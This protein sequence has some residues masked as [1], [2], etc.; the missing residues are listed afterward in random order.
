MSTSTQLSGLISGFD[1]KSFIDSTISYESVPINRMQREQTTNSA[2]YDA[3]GSLDGLL[4]SLRTSAQALGSSSSFYARTTSLAASTAS[5]SASADTGAALGAYKVS[6]TQ[7]ATAARLNGAGDIT[8]GLAATADVSGLTLS[9][10][11]LANTLTAGTF[12]VNGQQVTVDLADS[13]QDVFDAIATATSGAVTASYDPVTDTVALA[14]SGEIVLGAANDTSNFLS[15]FRLHNNGTASVASSTAL[16]ALA[17]SAPIASAGLRSAVTA[18]DGAG[19][20]SFSINGVSLDYNVNT[21]TVAS[22]IARINAS[23]AGV[24]ASYD[25]VNDRVVL[26]N[27]V[28]GD[29]GVTVT[30]AAGGL[31][32]ALG[33]T[34]GALTRGKNALY[35]IDDGP[36][37]VSA[38][39]TLAADSHGVTGLRLT[40]GATGTDTINVGAD[41]SAMKTKIQAFVT[42]YNNVQAYIDQQTK[43]TKTENVVSSATLTN[44]REVQAWSS[45]LRSKVFAAVGGLSGTVSRLESLGIDFSSSDST[46][47]VKSTT[48]LDAALAQ[49]PDDVAAFFATA[50]TG[51]AARLV[52]SINLI[53][54]D[55]YG[56]KGYIDNRQTE[57][58][59]ANLDLDDQIASF[60]RYLDQRREQLTAS[61]I[62]MENAQQTYNSIQTQ[63]TKSF[64][65]DNS[66]SK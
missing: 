23:A 28:T 12:T 51:F 8:R 30:E 7:L 10:L 43:I 33:L 32:G 3:L 66:S 26:A 24:T 50:G 60:Q 36:Q 46:L 14:G 45:T 38:S 53:A 16:G 34:G 4:V 31:L 58:T 21:D 52:D 35:S 15:A 25:S 19:A 2:K 27:K 37:L 56:S 59:D 63:L 13:L 49:R 40:V 5:W 9:T 44:E 48:T 20:G 1:W 18:V 55:E 17:L 65:S 62:A 29:S 54:G 39:N 47:L 11:P 22:V 61:F 41:T 6:V 57:L 42:A 64:F